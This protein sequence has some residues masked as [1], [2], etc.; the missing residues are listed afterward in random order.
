[1]ATKLKPA[2]VTLK[3]L[4]EY[5]SESTSDFSFELEVLK[6]LRSHHLKCEHGG[7]YEDPVTKKSR[8]FDIRALFES[9]TVSVQSSHL[10]RPHAVHLDCNCAPT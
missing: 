5:L 10:D 4:N 7:H 9:G 8:E 6:E 3:D 2:P 1:M